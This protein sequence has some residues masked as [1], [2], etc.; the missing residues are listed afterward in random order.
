M[1]SVALLKRFCWQMCCSPAF[2]G[3]QSL[4]QLLPLAWNPESQ[5]PVFG[6]LLLKASPVAMHSNE[7]AEMG[8]I[9]HWSDSLPVSSFSK[10]WASPCTSCKH[11]IGLTLQN[12]GSWRGSAAQLTSVTYASGE[13]LQSSPCR[14]AV[15]SL[16]RRL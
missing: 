7:F 6:Q 4:K 10:Q 15:H 2:H 8:S 1:H 12:L 16:D 5:H 13:V 11:G 14:A 3:P 9:T